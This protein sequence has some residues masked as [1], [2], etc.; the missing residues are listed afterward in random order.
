L[1]AAS[2][3]VGRENGWNAPREASRIATTIAQDATDGV[4]ILAAKWGEWM[5]ATLDA[6]LVK[7]ETQLLTP[8]HSGLANGVFAGYDKA[9]GL[10]VYA[11]ELRC[12][13]N[14]TPKRAIFRVSKFKITTDGIP[15]GFLGSDEGLTLF[16]EVSDG[17]T[18]RAKAERAAWVVSL[19]QDN[20]LAHDAGITIRT[21]EF[22]LRYS[23]APDVGG[24]IDAVALDSDGKIRWIQRK[25][26]CSD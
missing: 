11:V 3:T 7:N 15:K 1:F 26:N 21:L 24:S 23:G 17:N 14:E 25:P 4:E 10:A 18:E 19:P 22:I 6:E 2:G 8:L 12:A 20:S 5:R 9:N 13:C 16:N